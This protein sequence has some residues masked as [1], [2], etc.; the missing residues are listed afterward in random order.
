MASLLSC[1]S[2]VT[3]LALMISLAAFLKSEIVEAKEF[4]WGAVGDSV[5]ALFVAALGA[6]FRPRTRCGVIERA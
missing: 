6:L 5:A 3:W 2:G 1:S 4:C